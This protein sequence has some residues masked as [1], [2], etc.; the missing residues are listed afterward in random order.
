MKFTGASTYHS[1]RALISSVS[2]WNAQ[3]PGTALW[4]VRRREQLSSGSLG[5]AAGSREGFLPF[6][7]MDLGEG[8][9]GE[10]GWNTQSLQ[11][12]WRLNWNVALSLTS[13]TTEWERPGGCPCS[14]ACG[15]PDP[16][17]SQSWPWFWAGRYCLPCSQQPL[18]AGCNYT[19][20]LQRKVM[21]GVRNAWLQIRCF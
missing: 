6:K 13:T 1:N 19:L 16:G 14:K 3:V 12:L 4:D 18:A 10:G 15:F 8:E 21:R 2:L 20:Q 17:G 9:K 5:A 7:Q 11:Y